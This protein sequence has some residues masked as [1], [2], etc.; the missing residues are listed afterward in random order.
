[1]N[2]HLTS[3]EETFQVTGSSPAGLTTEE[4]AERLAKHGPNLLREKKKKPAWLMLLGQFK[5]VMILM[6]LAAAVIS[7]L[8]G[9]L[10][11]T[12]VILIIVVLNAVVGFVQEF[13]AE[14]AM[15]A[16]KKMSAPS[17]NVLRNNAPMVV[18]AG[19][20]VPG[21]IVTLEAGA[22]VPA[23]LRLLESFSLKIEEASLT[24]ESVA[25]DKQTEEL[26]GE[27]LPL[28]DRTSMAYKGTLIS[29]GRGT[30]VVVA[31]GM[32]TELGRIALLLQEDE[33]MTPLQKRLADFSK[34]ISL[35]VL[36]ICVVFLRG[37]LPAGRGTRSV[38][39]HRHLRGRGSHTRGTARRRH[40]RTGAWRTALGETKRPYPPTTCRGNAGFRHLYLHGQ[41]RYAHAKQH[42]RD[43]NM[44]AGNAPKGLDLDAKTLLLRCMA[45]NHDVK[46][47]EQ[48][49]L[50]GESTEVALAAYAAAELPDFQAED[51]PKRSGTAL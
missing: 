2:W 25:V 27:K 9:D 20:L 19:D 10:N 3:I 42:V 39:A 47:N 4:A 30:G 6:L 22:M 41:N 24:G 40:H 46:E 51:S 44:D 43:R 28:G 23:D 5:D 32:E 14:K 7:G 34:K 35:G 13:R 38:V 17:A 18:E 11:D 45:L 21:D 8:V 12:I 31:T 15:E 49:E 26:H 29:Y 36:G 48:G 16:L 37:G 50:V 33:A 1:M